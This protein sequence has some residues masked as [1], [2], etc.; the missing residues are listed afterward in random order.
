[1]SVNLSTSPRRKTRFFSAF[2]NAFGSV[3]QI[4]PSLSVCN[5]S[6]DL[7]PARLRCEVA[8]IGHCSFAAMPEIESNPALIR[9]YSP[10]LAKSCETQ[11]AD[12]AQICKLSKTIK[13]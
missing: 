1:M 2:S 7:L 9:S 11:R 13:T 10:A 3:L 6:S 12:F 4:A 5:P 8:R